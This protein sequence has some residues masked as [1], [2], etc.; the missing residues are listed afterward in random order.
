MLLDAGVFG[1][2]FFLIHSGV[3]E[4]PNVTED[5]LRAA[6]PELARLGATLIV[7]AEVPG[8]VEACCQAIERS[9]SRSYET[10]LRSR[11]REAENQ[12]VAVMIKLSRENGCRGHIVHH[13]SAE[14]LPMR[15]QAESFC[16]PA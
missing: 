9:S 11:P 12:A 2:K 10:F 16:P 4:F 13:S 1:F 5:D 14:A 7:H 3:D 6:M 15:P 8:P